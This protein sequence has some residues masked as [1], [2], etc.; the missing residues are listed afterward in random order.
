M[1]MNIPVVRPEWVEG[2]EREGRIV[3]VRGYYLGA[4][5]KL[6]MVG[7]PTG[8]QGSPQ[9]GQ[10]GS[11]RSLPQRERE[12][13]QQQQPQPPVTPF[14]G[15][16]GG[17]EEDERRGEKE[18]ERRDS[19]PPNVPAKDTPAVRGEGEE[20]EE[21]AVSPVAV[22]GE[23]T[24]QRISTA[25]DSGDVSPEEKEGEEEEAR[26]DAADDG[27]STP[28]TATGSQAGFSEVQL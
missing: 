27:G 14:P 8:G 2:C 24:R 7:P 10:G 12:Q 22:G 16:V 21:E 15:A 6:R 1:E 9:V 23:D 19:Q 3:G 11:E 13:Q 4:D 28:A 26:S 25:S 20:E 5:P 18:A 17:G